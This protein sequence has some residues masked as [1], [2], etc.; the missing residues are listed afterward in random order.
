MQVI[1][2]S[3][4]TDFRYAGKDYKV[5]SSLRKDWIKNQYV[6]PWSKQKTW[7]PLFTFE[8]C[9]VHAIVHF[10]KTKLKIFNSVVKSALLYG[11]ET[12]PVNKTVRKV[13]QTLVN[14]CLRNI[15]SIYWPQTIRNKAL[16]E[17]AGEK[18][19]V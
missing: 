4:Q 6:C 3:W 12:W 2:V 13:L 8:V 19:S 18:N 11:S 14:R 9:C 16:W 7:N 17:L 1:A 15:F 10:K 5:T